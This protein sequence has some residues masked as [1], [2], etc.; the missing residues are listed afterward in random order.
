M[1]GE[2]LGL[3]DGTGTEDAGG[4][5]DSFIEETPG[6]GEGGE[7]ETP[8]GD[9]EG[10]GEGDGEG[11]G[12]RSRA[13]VKVEP[14]A[15]RKALREISQ[16]NPDF[17]K[18]FPTLEKAVT[19]ALF[20]S[21]QI[22]KFGGIQAISEAAEALEVHG[23]LEGIQQMAEDNAANLE[24]QQGFERGDPKVIDGWAK[25]FP[26]GFKKL[27]APALDKLETLDKEHYTAVGS[28]IIGKLFSEYGVY[29]AISALGEALSAEKKDDAIK[30]FNA[31][32]KFLTDA[33]ALAANAK[34]GRTDR[35]AEL[36]SR[37]QEIAERDKKA[38][39]GS[40][41]QD[42]NTAVMSEMNRLI[43]L[44]LPKGRR[45]KVEPA[46]RLRKEIN[47]ELSRVVNTQSGYA[48]RYEAV[49]GA[50]DKDRAVRFITSQART[51]LP[52]VVKQ[53]LAEFNLTGSTGTNTN[54]QRRSAN[55][56]GNRVDGAVRTVAGVPK[57][58][59]VDFR[60]TD[61]ATFLSQKS[62]GRHG[63]AW[64]LSGKQAKW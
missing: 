20:K 10:G 57:T 51:Y 26:A 22:E 52:K 62:Q 9:G 5:D 7:P 12:E 28:Y 58:G 40:V 56:N 1:D 49:M 6:E 63:S 2:E 43:R 35:D 15:I 25:D 23:G 31:L 42:V 30:H 34:S 21:G 46:N 48:A 18:K 16:S 47:A 17:A 41:R 11:E 54:T 4:G 19:T 53:M 39:Y 61:K 24:L 8:G 3:L 27:I 45:I 13:I 37:E 29:G 33:K 60:K 44:G 32:A 50:R 38:F 55:G 64:L 14:L 36:D 59:D